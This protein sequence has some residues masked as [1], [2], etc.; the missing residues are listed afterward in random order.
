MATSAGRE[1][2]S[3]V[4]AG[5]EALVAAADVLYKA[6]R[7]DGQLKRFFV[8]AS[9]ESVISLAT[10]LRRFLASAFD[11]DEWPM[12]NISPAL[13]GPPAFSGLADAILTAANRPS[14]L[15]ED[16]LVAAMG[17]LCKDMKSDLR[18]QA[19]YEQIRDA[20]D[21]GASG[22]YLDQ[23]VASDDED[24][25]DGIDAGEGTAAILN[26]VRGAADTEVN[27]SSLDDMVMGSQQAEETQRCWARFLDSFASSEEAG[28]AIYAA[29]FDAAPSLQS[30]FKTPRAVMSMR[31]M[32]GFNQLIQG[33]QD[34]KN[35]RLLVETLGFRHLDLDV[36]VPRVVIFRDAI[37]DLVHSELGDQLTKP[38]LDGLRWTLDYAGGGFIF[39]RATYAERLKIIASSWRTASGKAADELEAGIGEE[40]DP[41]GTLGEVTEET[42]VP[43]SSSEMSNKQIMA[44]G[45]D[46]KSKNLWDR[47][48]GGNQNDSQEDSKQLGKSTAYD[49]SK[50][51]TGFT[52]MQGVPTTYD[53]MFRFNA[54]VM[55]L[56][57]NL[58]MYEVL[59]SFDAI[60]ANVAN[61]Y[62]LQEECDVLSLRFAKLTG[63][64][65]LPEYKAVMLA[66][67]RSLVPK[68]WNSAHEVAWN[69][70]WENVERLLQVQ[71]GKPMA[72]QRLLGRYLGSLEEDG[73]QK[74]RTQFFAKFFELAPAGQDYFKQSTSRLYFIADRVLD[75]SLDLY[76]QPKDMVDDISA[77][78]L[79]H[80]GYGIPT[81]LFDPFATGCIQ[82]LHELTS[83]SELADAFGWSVGLMCRLM[84]R[85]INEGS[86]TVMKAI[87]TN[88]ANQAKKALA[89]A[90]RGKRATWMLNISVGTQSISPF[91]WSI[92]SGSMEVAKIIMTDLLT[93]RADR[94]KYY[95]GVD[96]LFQR[97]PDIVQILTQE[98]PLLVPTM[99]DGMLWRSRVAP[100][101]QR[102][103]NIYLKNLLVNAEGGFADALHWISVMQDPRIVTQPVVVSLTDLVWNSIIYRS[104]L[105]SKTWLLF[106]LVVFLLSQSILKNLNTGNP[107]ES[108]RVAIFVCRAF[109]YLCSMTELIYCRT[110]TLCK[111]MK[112]GEIVRI[113]RV[114]VPKCYV[115]D[116]CETVSVLLTL[117][118]IAMFTQE[119]ILYCL[120][121]S[122]EGLF[123]E[124]CPAASGVAESYATMSMVA[125]LLY[126]ALLIDFSALSTDLSAFVLVAGRVLP[127]L[128]LYLLAVSFMI[129]AFASSISATNEVNHDFSGIP[130][131]GLTLFEMFLSMYPT[132]RFAALQESPSTFTWV[133]CFQII[134]TIFLTS[135]LI[136]QL[137]GSYQEVYGSMV[138]NARI[139]RI[140]IIVETMPSIR[141]RR[142]HRFIE[143]LQLAARLEF[144]EGD[145]GLPGGIQVL[146]PATLHPTNFDSIRRFGGSTSPAMQWPEEH[147]D[148]DSEADRFKRLEKTI[149]R[150]VKKMNAV[151]SGRKGKK[152]SSMSASD[153]EQ[154]QSSS[155]DASGS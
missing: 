18:V 86:T 111:A 103:V 148:E 136:A 36:T 152:E 49:S 109:V 144:G 122:E 39:I 133:A 94:D 5:D 112:N 50:I 101:G 92:S 64:T 97:H 15:G 10:I 32:M 19:F 154:G 30:L 54:A 106:T 56:A 140:E 131:S 116:W 48:A 87:N 146:E 13:V 142:F 26:S 130:Q 16:P 127:E 47:W 37:L 68:D 85:A 114:P 74:W 139:S 79:R 149:L 81:E 4:L 98:A 138:G 75:M 70:L 31:I 57:N 77:L 6:L 25:A 82:V 35:V 58:W 155:A 20:V 90:P 7:A 17:L 137:N 60:V 53:E 150:A 128:G 78:G 44:E 46:K 125:M 1:L 61:T 9:N 107:T 24:V 51:N 28:E 134:V 132:E 84:V 76:K 11:G 41:S 117:V 80:V 88:S 102:R 141:V 153:K 96:E 89:C 21:I 3:E 126:F 124:A 100:G 67:L 55:G 147:D 59:A 45:K 8:A 63:T 93:I 62:R 143:S 72:M 108:E 71:L 145:V 113:G 151:S 34:G 65:R 27:T 22:S 105:M 73:R 33:L 83:D 12:L 91:L 104:F 121:N 38:A 123:T 95:Y 43:G 99:L 135:L 52:K 110:K 119:P 23:E 129:V 120:Q 2:T 40:A 69:W 42:S 118:L 14:P 66:S 115:E 29:I